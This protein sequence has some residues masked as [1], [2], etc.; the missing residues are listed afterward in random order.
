MSSCRGA[1][2]Q[3]EIAHYSRVDSTSVLVDVTR[4][5]RFL[6]PEK[7]GETAVFSVTDRNNNVPLLILLF[8]YANNTNGVKKKEKKERKKERKK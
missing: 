5:H 7:K 4:G 3:S 1:L 2:F 6:F 8:L